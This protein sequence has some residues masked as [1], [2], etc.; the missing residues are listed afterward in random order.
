M[1][2][3]LYLATDANNLYDKAMTEPLPYGNFKL[4]N[5]SHMTID[6]I[7]AYNDEGEDC[8]IFEV[9][10]KYREKVHDNHNDYPLAPEVII[11]VKANSLSPY[12]VELYK[13]T[14]SLPKKANSLTD[15]QMDEY[16]KSHPS[17]PRDEKSPKLTANLND[18]E[19]YV[20]HIKPLKNI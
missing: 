11:Y 5:P 12:Q 18:K 19:Q 9:D 17:K 16:I 14:Q 13:K 7:K 3:V 10:S 8:Y 6:F 15:E 2:Q 1:E 4:F 20:L